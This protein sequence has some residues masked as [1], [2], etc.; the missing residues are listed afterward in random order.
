M[1]TTHR[2]L[3][4]FDIDGTLCNIEHRLH[5]LDDKT[6]KDRW[7][8]FY[9]ACVNDAPNLPVIRTMNLL[10]GADIWLFSGRSEEVRA[11]T[12][13]WLHDHTHFNSNRLLLQPEMLT[14]RP[15]G[16]YTEDHLL[17]Q[18]WLHNMLEIDRKR[19]IAIFDDRKRVVDM[20]R[21]N[22]VACFQVADGEF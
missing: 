21:D 5:F 18:S 20:W 10:V 12:I 15:V 8:K 6:D 11:E 1:P 2:P 9:K 22:G 4:I 7:K 13:K 16:D 17:K 19:L 3:Y 14:M